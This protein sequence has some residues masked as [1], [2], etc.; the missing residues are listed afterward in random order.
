MSNHRRIAGAVLA[1]TLT[2]G[3]AGAPQA[4]AAPDS[5]D[6]LNDGRSSLSSSP[7]AAAPAV[8]MGSLMG[9]VLGKALFGGSSIGKNVQPVTP[10]TDGPIG[11]LRSVEQISPTVWRVT[12]YSPS[13]DKEI[14]NEVIAPVGGPD[15]LTPRPTYYMLGGAGGT[16]WTDYDGTVEFFEDK[17]V[18]VVSPRGTR[19]TMVTDW[20][21][22][23]D[24]FGTLKWATY[25][26]H[27]LPPVI[28]EVFHGTGRDAIAG[29]SAHGGPALMIAT[30]SDRFVAA[31][32]Y[33][34]CPSTSGLVGKNFARL[35]VRFYKGDPSKMWG[36]PFSSA[37]EVNSA[38]NNLDALR[39]KTLFLTASRGI[40]S[41]HDDR[42]TDSPDFLLVPDEQ[43]AYVCSRH[44][45]ARAD[46]KG[47][48]YDWYELTEG[49]H[50][51]GTFK[52]QLPLTWETV[53]PALG[54][55]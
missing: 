45:M 1:A 51:M 10:D 34:S 36:G 22:P 43:V 32:T 41:E 53:G 40:H 30:M 16:P 39:D 6:P 35:G 25:M 17:N 19:G 13:M 48:D 2:F 50:N 11:E 26:A 52:R 3:A 42:M 29:A 38:V 14:V 18:N 23:H 24:E 12:V 44:F 27:E 15:N 5:P 9:G 8:V 54:V 21:E 37:W 49:T 33:S 20:N 7:I 47:V 4:I 28:D 46:A 55:E 31:G